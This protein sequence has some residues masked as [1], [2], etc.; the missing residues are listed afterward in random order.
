MHHDNRPRRVGHIISQRISE[1][2][3]LLDPKTGAYY[4]LD[5]VGARVWELCDGSRTISETV[6][7][8]CAEYDADPKAIEADVLNLLDELSREQLVDQHAITE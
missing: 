2:L 5:G 6:A 8:I 7:S 1:K 3:V 4:S